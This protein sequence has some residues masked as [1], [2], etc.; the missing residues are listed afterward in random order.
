MYMTSATY[1]VGALVWLNVYERRGY[2]LILVG[3]FRVYQVPCN[4]MWSKIYAVKM[5]E[6]IFPFLFCLIVL[7]SEIACGNKLLS[8]FALILLAN[9]TSFGMMVT[10]LAWI[11]HKLVSS[12]KPTKYAWTLLATPRPRRIG[13]ASQS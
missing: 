7:S 11:A 2:S 1:V 3:V 4:I 6:R 5:V 10:L 8:A 12:N 9:W 13:I